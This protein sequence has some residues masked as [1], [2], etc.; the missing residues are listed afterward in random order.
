MSYRIRQGLLT[1]GSV[2]MVFAA[3]AQANPE[4]AASTMPATATSAPTVVPAADTPTPT[5]TPTTA[6]PSP[7]GTAPATLAPPPSAAEPPALPPLDAEHTAKLLPDPPDCPQLQ[8]WAHA[9]RQRFLGKM[10]DW[11]RSELPDLH[12]KTVLYPFSGPDIATAMAMFPTASH[13]TLVA[14][15]VAEYPY[16]SRA[17]VAPANVT[18]AECTILSRFKDMG[19]YVTMELNGAESTSVARPGFLPLLVAGTVFMDTKVVRA[20]V[21]T[22]DPRGAVREI[23]AG[24]APARGV[25]LV[26]EFPTG[27]RATVDY[28]QIDLSD[29]GLAGNAAARKFMQ[30]DTDVLFLKSASH[31]LQNPAFST[32]AGDFTA[33]RAPYIVQDETGLDIQRLQA[34]WF[35]TAYGKFTSPHRSWQNN[36]HALKLVEYYRNNHSAGELPFKIGYRKEAGSALL[37]GRRRD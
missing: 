6:P 15:Q 5:E 18:K 35:V 26:V 14:D 34:G 32:L 8:E 30:Q 4:P 36:P 29:N 19:F 24:S 37:V 9:W 3:F 25:R 28:V 1:F 33:R 10:N 7:A 16:L 2:L 23:P 12:P 21:L 20:A 11:V 22:L 13:Y 17:R 31:L 27:R